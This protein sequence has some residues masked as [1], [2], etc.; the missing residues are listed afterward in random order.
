MK[1]LKSVTIM[2]LTKQRGNQMKSRTVLACES[3]L[4]SLIHSYGPTARVGWPVVD[5]AIILN[6]GGDTR[7]LKRFRE[8]LVVLDFL[9]EAGDV[10]CFNILKVD[11]KQTQ[12]NECL[13]TEDDEPP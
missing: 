8:Q 12:L 3:I 13:V 2:K 10:V 11:F 5:K 4:R 9:R 7:T 1:N 6:A